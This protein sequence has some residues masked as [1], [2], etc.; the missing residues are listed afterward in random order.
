MHV[1]VS[2]ASRHGSTAELAI[3]LANALEAEGVTTTVLA[4]EAAVSLDG[5]DAVV[6][7][8]AVYMGH[9]LEAARRWAE[10]NAAALRERPVWL[11]SSGPVGDPLRPTEDPVDI[12]ALMPLTGALEHRILPGRL[13]RR[14]LGFSEKAIAAAVRVAEGDFRSWEDVRSW[15]RAIARQLRTPATPVA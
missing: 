6:I 10:R 2:V 3:A 7:G 13:V 1:L 15:G 11:F 12:A 8:S 5:Y 14:E 4:P 9:W